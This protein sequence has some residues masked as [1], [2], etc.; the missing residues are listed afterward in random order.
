MA[1]NNDKLS[2]TFR[3]LGDPTRRD[4]L[5]RL[6]TNGKLVVTDIANE[7]KMSLP[8][9][10]KHL[11]VLEKA[12]LVKR[13]KDGQERPTSIVPKNL[14]SAHNWLEQYK[15][16]WTETLDSLEQYLKSESKKK[17]QRRKR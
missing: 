7:Y 10:T 3:A 15:I 17:R 5:S 4:I 16:Y 11:K 13:E 12:G 8:A 14:K 6:T 2:L 9:I 1:T